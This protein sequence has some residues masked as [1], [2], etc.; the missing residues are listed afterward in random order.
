MTG[1]PEAISVLALIC[2][3]PKSPDQTQVI[4]G[5]NASLFKRLASLCKETT[6]VNLSQT[7]GLKASCVMK[8]PIKSAQV[9]EDVGQVQWL[10]SKPVTLPP[11][12][13]RRIDCHVEMKHPFPHETLMLG[14]S[15]TDPMPTGV[16]LEPV[17]VKKTEVRTERF[18]VHV[19]NQSQR[20]VNILWGQ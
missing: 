3:G 10:G 11:Q 13:H 4:L 14:A 7:L 1:L 6:G 20:E 16:F 12:S 19:Q 18:P 15:D 8:P 2:P 5:T 17:V 9:E